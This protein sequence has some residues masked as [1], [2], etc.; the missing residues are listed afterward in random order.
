[1]IRGKGEVEAAE[2]LEKSLVS[3]ARGESEKLVINNYE[4]LI[5]PV[6]YAFIPTLFVCGVSERAFRSF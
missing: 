6:V 5:T 4:L 1:V 2:V 3:M